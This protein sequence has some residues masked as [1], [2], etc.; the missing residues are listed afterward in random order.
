M[1]IQKDWSVVKL[2]M[3]ADP[4]EYIEEPPWQRG[5]FYYVKPGVVRYDGVE[6][7]VNGSFSRYNFPKYKELHYR[8]KN[9]VENIIGE[10]LYPTY[11]F[12]RFYFKGNELVPHYDR[13]SCE[14]SVSF[15]V[16]DNLDYEWPLYFQSDTVSRVGLT[17]LPGDGVL[18]RGCELTHWREPMKGDYKSY[19]HQVFFHYVRADGYCVQHAFDHHC[20]MGQ[21]K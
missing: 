14:I 7:Q 1:S 2:Q 13:D 10:K 12:D 5:T 17:C 18:Y 4:T 15:H 9:I 16:S 20:E 19:F 8:I 3:L 11:Y 6:G 21:L